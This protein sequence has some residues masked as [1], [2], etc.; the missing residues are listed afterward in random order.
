[1][2][3]G[4]YRVWIVVGSDGERREACN[5]E[6][7]GVLRGTTGGSVVLYDRGDF[8]SGSYRGHSLGT[9]GPYTVSV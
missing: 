2:L 6:G 5:N 8:G 1:M 9:L 3:R 7:T 4:N